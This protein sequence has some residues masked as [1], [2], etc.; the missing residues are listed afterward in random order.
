MPKG[1]RGAKKPI[2]AKAIDQTQNKEIAKI[3]KTIKA[4]EPEIKVAHT[5]I[6]ATLFD[7]SLPRI[8]TLNG[9]TKGTNVNQRLGNKVRAKKLEL[10]F[11]VYANA[12]TLLFDTL[13]RVMVVRE[14]TSLGSLV[15]LSGLLGSATPL[16]YFVQ[17][18]QT[19]D[20]SRYHILKDTVF[21]IGP[22]SHAT[23]AGTTPTPQY[24]SI[25]D[26]KV[27]VPLNL[28]VDHA[29]GN[30]GDVTD[31]DTNGLFIIFITDVATVSALSVRGEYNY[32]FMDS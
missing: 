21:G 15:S 26:Y 20:T 30:V 28:V 8:F 5:T 24:P 9:L 10:S 2:A 12:P 4:I 27:S 17:N 13:V 14:K 25:R 6:A 31:I 18:Y 19:R 23:A 16:T 11:Q 22:V 1:K 32:M 29:R 7:N 3:K